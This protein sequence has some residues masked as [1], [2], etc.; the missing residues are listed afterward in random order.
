VVLPG[1]ARSTVEE[2]LVVG[3]ETGPSVF[4]RQPAHRSFDPRRVGL[5]ERDAW[6][7]YYTRHWL[8]LLGVSVALVGSTFRMGPVGTLRGAWHVLRANQKW[9]P[10]PDNDPD[11]AR[12]HMASFYRLLHRY[13]GEPMDAD[14]AARL[15]VEWWRTHR[16]LQRQSGQGGTTVEELVSALSSLYAYLYH[17]EEGAVELAARERALAMVLSD[18]WVADGCPPNSPLLVA[19]GRHLVRSYAALL[20]AVYA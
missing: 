10:F 16:L 8:R 13:H 19:E 9:A 5:L 2:R 12:R 7:A 20:G 11:E 4:G 6:V 15:E 17:V 18:S 14:A 1:T 3:D